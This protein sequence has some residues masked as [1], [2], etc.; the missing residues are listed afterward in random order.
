MMRLIAA[1]RDYTGRL[2]LIALSTFLLPGCASLKAYPDRSGDATAELKSL[3]TYFSPDVMTKYDAADDGARG[4]L[5]KQQWRDQVVNGRIRAVDLH[6]LDF[7]QNVFREG[8]ESAIAVDWVVLALNAAGSLS[9]GA[10]NALAATSAGLVGA[11]AAFDKHALFERTL[12]SL[13]G[14]IGSCQ[15]L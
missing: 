2:V 10:A 13:M 3:E 8:V 15:R 11:K 14:T 1:M 5:T 7:Q 4:G 12:P 9:G 6:F